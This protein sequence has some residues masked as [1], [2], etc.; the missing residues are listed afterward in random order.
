MT[1]LVILRYREKQYG[2][3]QKKSSAGG[4]GF[5][6]EGDAYLLRILF[7]LDGVNVMP[8]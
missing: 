8:K 5:L 6:A 3:L 4:R 2:M 7:G 1:V